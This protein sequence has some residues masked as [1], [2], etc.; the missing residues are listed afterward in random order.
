MNLHVSR[1]QQAAQPGGPANRERFVPAT[2]ARPLAGPA[3]PCKQPPSL[4][5]GLQT[6]CHCNPAAGPEMLASA[7]GEQKGGM[8]G[9]GGPRAPEGPSSPSPA[10]CSSQLGPAPAGPWGSPGGT[11]VQGRHKLRRVWAQARAFGAEGGL[12]CPQAQALAEAPGATQR[13]RDTGSCRRWPAVPTLSPAPLYGPH[14]PDGTLGPR[15]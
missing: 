5:R 8:R 13:R 2:H 1:R 7:I 12:T 15:W 4:K 11:Q 14:V 6:Q 10:A 3:S 9:S